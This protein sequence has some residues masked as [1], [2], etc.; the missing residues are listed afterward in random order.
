MKTTK[1]IEGLV[2]QVMVTRF[3]TSK[4]KAGK[5][6]RIKWMEDT[7]IFDASLN[8]NYEEDV[9]LYEVSEYSIKGVRFDKRTGLQRFELVPDMDF[10]LKPLVLEYEEQE[11]LG[12][13]MKGGKV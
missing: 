1:Y 10:V 5:A 9:F 2:E 4:V 13:L 8:K 11:I 7:T 12:N 6:Y 3:N